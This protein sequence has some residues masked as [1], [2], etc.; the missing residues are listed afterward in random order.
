[1]PSGGDATLSNILW[2]MIDT[3]LFSDEMGYDIGS[4]GYR[5]VSS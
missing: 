1:M 3:K 4:E 5:N 2:E